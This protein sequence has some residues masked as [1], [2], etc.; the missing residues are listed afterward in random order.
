MELSRTRPTLI[1]T[2]QAHTEDELMGSVLHELGH[3]LGYQGHARRGDTVMVASVDEVR[4]AGRRVLAGEPLRDDTLRALY[5]LPSGSIGGRIDVGRA[6]TG[7]V[8]HLAAVAERLELGG[9]FVRVGDRAGQILWRD[10]DGNPY[11]FQIPRIAEVV[12][13]PT[14]L[15]LFPSTRTTKLL[16]GTP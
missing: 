14:N 2:E 9:P 16:G 15:E 5:A 6:R 8:D 4:W 1:G 10:A 3:A 13:D 12:R 11:G 7:R